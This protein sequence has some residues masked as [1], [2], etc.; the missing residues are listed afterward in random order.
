MTASRVGV[1]LGERPDKDA[2]IVRSY[3]VP[4]SAKNLSFALDQLAVPN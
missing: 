4:C 2:S 1:M 3:I